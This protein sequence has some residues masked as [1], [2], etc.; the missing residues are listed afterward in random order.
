MLDLAYGRK[1]P[2]KWSIL[3]VRFVISCP[4]ETLLNSHSLYSPTLLYQPPLESY[5]PR[6]VRVHPY[7]VLSSR[8]YSYLLILAH[9]GRPLNHLI[10]RRPQLY[11]Q[12]QIHPLMMLVSLGHS[13]NVEKSTS[14]GAISRTN[15]NGCTLRLRSP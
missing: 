3:K 2:L 6:S 14:A 9:L 15:G 7:T 4:F 10:L 1:G 5:H 13:A 12:G 8:R 11:R